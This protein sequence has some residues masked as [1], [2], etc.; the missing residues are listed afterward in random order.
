MLYI[1]NSSLFS[2][3]VQINYEII[4]IIIVPN[5]NLVK[6]HLR[7]PSVSNYGNLNNKTIIICTQ[8]I[9]KVNCFYINLSS[10]ICQENLINTHCINS[11]YVKKT[12]VMVDGHRLVSSYYWVVRR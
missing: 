4:N 10:S 8:G 12:Y 9:E 11:I 5:C 3:H 7:S 6:I 2:I 1:H